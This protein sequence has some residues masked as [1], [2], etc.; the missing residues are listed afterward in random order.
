[1][2]VLESCYLAWAHALQWQQSLVRTN[3][4]VSSAF[5]AWNGAFNKKD[6]KAV[7]ALY[8]KDAVV[9][10]ATHEVKKNSR[11]FASAGSPGSLRAVKANSLRTGATKLT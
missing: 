1:M 5:R 3:D 6:A 11:T 8:T 10:P 9:L 7:A 2:S 4:A